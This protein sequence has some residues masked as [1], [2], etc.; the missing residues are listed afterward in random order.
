MNHLHLSCTAGISGNMFIGLLLNLGAD[1]A[2]FRDM[3]ASLPIGQVGLQVEKVSRKGIA[4]TYFDTEIDTSEQ[5]AHRHLSHIQDIINQAPCASEVRRKALDVFQKLGEAEA[6]VH[7]TTIEKVHFH[8]VGAVDTIV[9]ILG[10]CYLLQ[11]LGI[12]TITFSDLHTGRGFVDCAHGRLPL[13]APATTELLNGIPWQ[14]GEMEKELVTPTG[15]ALLKTL[16]Q[17]QPD[18]PRT[19]RARKTA[20]GAGGYDLPIPNVL[21]GFQGVKEESRDRQ[22][23]LAE[24]NLD[25]ATPEWIAWAAEKAMEAGAL[26]C[27]TEPIVMKKGRSGHK[28]CFLCAPE[29]TDDLTTIVFQETTTLGIRM[30]QVNRRETPWEF[31]EVQTPW[32]IVRAKKSGEGQHYTPEYEDCKNLA[33]QTGRSLREIYLAASTS[34]NADARQ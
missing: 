4:A 16:A 21:R 30:H 7:D 3:V 28:F 20:Y 24:A 12:Q 10:A 18:L 33:Q 2:D 5:K 27:W 26:D 19:F 13:P 23:V 31:Q 29:R 22:L 17:W 6:K 11:K 9:D 1:E 8:E 14:H 15:A 32:G 34:Q 25:D